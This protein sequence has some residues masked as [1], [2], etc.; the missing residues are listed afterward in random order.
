LWDL[1]LDGLGGV[2]AAILGALY[3][4]HS[5]RSRQRVA[6]FAAHADARGLTTATANAELDR[7]EGMTIDLATK[8]AFL[9]SQGA[10]DHVV[11]CVKTHMAWVFLSER[12]AWKIKKPIRLPY[13]D[14]STVERRRHS[15]LQE[16]RL[17][18]RLA[19]NVYLDVVPLV[20]GP[21]G[22]AL[23]GAGRIVDWL[24]VMRRLPSERM[25]PQMLARGAATPADADALGDVLVA[26]YR[27][28]V[29]AP[30]SGASYRD[31]LRNT[32]VA[33]AGELVERG[34]ARSQIG[35]IV[36]AQLAGI[37]RETV[38]L[39]RR[40]A[41]GRV[42][43]AHG[44]LRPEH[45]CLESPPVVI[46]PLEF[47][48]ELRMLDAASELVFFALECERLRATWFGSRVLARY[49][50][51]SGDRVP[52]AV[53][54]LYRN[55]HALT[56]ALIALRHLDDAE[57]ADQPRWRAKADEY[58]SGTIGAAPAQAP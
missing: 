10:L 16:L 32:I 37:E 11:E 19:A 21:R 39:D 6:Q 8:L 33:D 55:Q 47:D 41:D 46:D 5:K 48:D 23:G 26:F 58:L 14:H 50:E 42:V 54:A 29:R 12:R 17:G 2:L 22:L 36:Q 34:A 15:C 35:A 57:P 4:H 13:L 1:I 28:A 40:I 53:A 9:R 52:P 7:R 49:A 30:W 27:D 25:L 56:R 3:M 20:A 45:V 38:S 43:D 51:R 31:R 18:R 24:V 44:D